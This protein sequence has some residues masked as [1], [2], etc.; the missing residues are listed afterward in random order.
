[1]KPLAALAA[2]AAL[3]ITLV[4]SLAP[5]SAAR[6]SYVVDDAHLGAV[7]AAPGLPLVA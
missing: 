7:D 6:S 2:F 3:S 5:A 4:A 1:M